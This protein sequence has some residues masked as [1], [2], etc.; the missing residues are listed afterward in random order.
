MTSTNINYVETYFEYPTLT[1]IHGA[2]TYDTLKTLKD[3]LKANATSVTSDL[4]GGNHGHLG[5]VLDAPEY[6]NVSV[7]P[8]VRPLHPGNLRIH[9]AQ[10]STKLLG[11]AMITRRQF[12]YSAKQLTL[13]KPS[14]NSW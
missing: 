2:P 8:Y 13:K 4:G 5:L 12:D 9:L 14:S 6:V 7:V 11:F 3:Q 1:R 10:H